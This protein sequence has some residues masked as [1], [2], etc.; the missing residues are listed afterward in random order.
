MITSFVAVVC[1][2]A[3]GIEVLWRREDTYPAL[4][5]QPQ[6]VALAYLRASRAM[7]LQRVEPGDILA[8]GMEHA[9]VCRL[10]HTKSSGCV[11]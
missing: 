4:A 7:P 9:R 10:R 2:G 8:D 11:L 5:V 3:I 6:R 1:I